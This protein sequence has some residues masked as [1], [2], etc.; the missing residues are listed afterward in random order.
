[1]PFYHYHC[2]TIQDSLAGD[3]DKG[4]DRSMDTHQT[5]WILKRE[6]ES[7]AAYIQALEKRNKELEALL[8]ATSPFQA[9]DTKR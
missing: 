1:M 3:T 5:N 9:S 7:K 2:P 4:G 6:N 8:K